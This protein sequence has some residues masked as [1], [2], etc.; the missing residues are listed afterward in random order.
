MMIYSVFVNKAYL[1]F[2][3]CLKAYLSEKEGTL[4]S[5]IYACSKKLNTSKSKN[6][7][8]RIPASS[9]IRR[10]GVTKYLYVESMGYCIYTVQ[11]IV[12]CVLMSSLVSLANNN[13]R[14]GREDGL[15]DGRTNEGNSV[16][17]R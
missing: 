15:Q 2:N 5:G 7:E 9:L 12:L 14:I 8:I 17:L 10:L 13:L 16:P 4:F 6:M 1:F 11:H 3:R